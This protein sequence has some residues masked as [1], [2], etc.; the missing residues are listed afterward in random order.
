[1]LAARII[2]LALC[3]ACSIDL[4]QL[5]FS[6]ED[7]A[8]CGSTHVCDKKN[9]VCVGRSIPSPV[10]G[11]GIVDEGEECDDADASDTCEHCRLLK[12]I[13]VSCGNFT[14]CGLLRDGTLRCKG[15]ELDVDG[16]QSGQTHPPEDLP[17][18]VDIEL[19]GR[20][21]CGIDVDRRVHCWGSDLQDYE[22]GPTRADQTHVPDDL[23]PFA[24]LRLGQNN[25]CV[26]DPDGRA[27]CWGGDVFHQSDPPSR[28]MFSIAP[29]ASFAC[30]LDAAT[31][32]A[33]C[34]GNSDDNRLT[35][36]PDV[37]FRFLR[38]AHFHTCGITVD[39]DIRCWG[40]ED[41][42]LVP[43]RTR[44]P[45]GHDFVELDGGMD[46][47]CARKQDNS[48]VC[49]GRRNENEWGQFDPPPIPFVKIV[50]GA[51]HNCGLTAEG[52]IVC[53]GREL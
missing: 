19:R 36:P 53:W 2:P 12:Y 48:V 4:D 35:A 22:R 28:A 43:E 16:S 24:E 11:D 39:G 41:D 9:H 29:G 8:S 38:A 7:D 34:W 21:A 49:W 46:H 10:C 33:F 31:T 40:V 13:D 27:I 51:L 5:A 1:M 45:E 44:P 37:K 18:L 17:P 15:D 23:P 32:A 26:V 52:T 47:T 42:P 30:A 50:S 6:C 14:M 25:T 3:A 20:H